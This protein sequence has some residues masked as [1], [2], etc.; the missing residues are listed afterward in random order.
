MSRATVSAA[1]HMILVYLHALSEVIQHVRL[2]Q[3]RSDVFATEVELTGLLT[4]K[5]SSVR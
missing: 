2:S 3:I 4:M 1:Y 5:L